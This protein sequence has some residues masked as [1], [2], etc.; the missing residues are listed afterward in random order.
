MMKSISFLKFLGEYPPDN[1]TDFAILCYE[2][3]SLIIE[4][5][6]ITPAILPGVM[7]KTPPATAKKTYAALLK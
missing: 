1:V 5:S 4:R 7:S 6:T 2:L 3:S